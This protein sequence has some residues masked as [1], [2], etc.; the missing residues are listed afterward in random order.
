MGKREVLIIA[1]FVVVGAL[2]YQFTAPPSTG[3]SSFSFANIFSEARRGMRGN[4]GRAN[5]THTAT[6]PLEAGHRELRI[7]RVS[8]SVTVVGEDRSDIEYALTVSSDG[9]D[10]E[11][12][13]AYADKTVFE[14]DDVAESLVL[15]VS[16]PDEASQQSTLVV[17]VPARLAVRVENAVGVTMTGVASAHIESA[18]GEVTLTDIAGAVTGAHQDDDVTVTNA[19]SVKLRLLRLRSKFENVRDGL[20]LDARDGECTILKSAGAVEV[21]S[22]RAEITVTGQRGPTIVRGSDG[23]VTLD[24]PGAE[25]KVDMRR[26]EVEVTLT[27]NVPV[28]ILTTDQTARVIIKETASVELDAMSTS[29]TIQAADVNLTPETVGENTKLVHTFGTGRGARVTIRNTR[30]EIVVRR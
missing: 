19:G 15:R 16:Y 9:P 21:E 22:Q 5:V 30:G 11:T 10:D 14:R 13:K 27:G 20:T 3:T 12:A 8:Q 23:R 28:T 6:I 24:S 2:V 18:R 4:P 25:S 17:K 26:T 7:L 1:G 29:G